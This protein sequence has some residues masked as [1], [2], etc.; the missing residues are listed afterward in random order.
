MASALSGGGDALDRGDVNQQGLEA[1]FSGQALTA[2]S[3]GWLAE[4]YVANQDQL[5]G[6]VNYESV[7][8]TLNENGEL[9]EPLVLIYPREGI[10]TADYPLMLLNADK[11]EAYDR[12]V[13][14]LRSPEFQ[15]E[16][17]KTTLRR[18]VVPGITL[19]P[20]IPD[21]LLVE[22]PFPSNLE[23]ID[24][25]LFS[26]LD[27]TR[28]PPHAFFVLDVSGSMEGDRLDDL[29]SAMDN[30]TGLDQSL[31]GRFSRFRN[32]ELI[33]LIPFSTAVEDVADFAVDDVAADSADMAHVRE[34][35]S[36]LEAGGDTAIYSALATAYDLAAAAKAEDPDRYYSVVLMTDG[37]LTA[38]LE[39]REFTRY[40]NSL[41]QEIRDI[42]TFTVLFGGAN[43][44]EME[45]I[46]DLTG[47]RMFDA[48][49]DSLGL[50]FK[51]IR[52]YQ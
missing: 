3:S 30:L 12:L 21:P 41:P 8:L 36:R 51:E 7:L 46:A 23:T 40:Y 32:R 2:G 38:G 13:T 47:G 5:D 18:P 27:E 35:V 14:Y 11:R 48:K 50:V 34:Y 29:K 28:A 4:S 1:F 39:P 16:M 31:T 15:E 24:A 10:I 52:G 37:E 6:I 26:F 33:T 9:Q 49:A 20:R 19:D 17:M 43:Q 42:P 22:L 45:D 44:G 25:L